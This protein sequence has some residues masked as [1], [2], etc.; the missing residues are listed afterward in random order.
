MATQRLPYKRRK[1]CYNRHR[2]CN[3]RFGI[4]DLPHT[5]TS[6]TA[7]LNRE[8]RKPTA[9]AVKDK[10]KKMAEA[11]IRIREID[12][13]ENFLGSMTLALSNYVVVV[14]H[15]TNLQD[16]KFLFSVVRRWYDYQCQDDSKCKYIF[17]IHNFRTTTNDKERE[18]LF[19]VRTLQKYS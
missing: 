8:P 16:Q 2:L 9:T 11:N 4:V 19:L 6:L 5:G 7:F 12:D 3:K 10:E 17:V 18:E 15:E 13:Y 14:M 1:V